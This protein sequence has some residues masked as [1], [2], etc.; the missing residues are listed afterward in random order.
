MVESVILQRVLK[1]VAMIEGHIRN[2]Y[3]LAADV[4]AL[5][6]AAWGAFA[7][8]FGWL[9]LSSRAEFTLF[10]L[11]AVLVKIPVFYGF[12]LYLRYWIATQPDD[13]LEN[14]RESYR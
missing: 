1:V 6:L 9:F 2:R 8:R 14:R 4:V 10:L 13:C 3:V 12:G 5:A 11:C 7:L